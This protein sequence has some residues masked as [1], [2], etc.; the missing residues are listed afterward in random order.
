MIFS[1]TS[2]CIPLSSFRSYRSLYVLTL[3]LTLVLTWAIAV[4]IRLQEGRAR[5]AS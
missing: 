1:F 2:H 4:D 5:E 3:F